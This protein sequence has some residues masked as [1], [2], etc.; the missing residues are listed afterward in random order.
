MGTG[1][2]PGVKRPGRGVNHPSQPSAEVKERVEL[3]L[4][5]PS[6]PSWPVIGWT[7]PF[8]FLPQQHDWL[9]KRFTRTYT[10]VIQ[11]SSLVSKSPTTSPGPTLSTVPLAHT[12][13]SP[14]VIRQGREADHSP[15]VSAEVKN[16]WKYTFTPS[17]RLHGVCMDLPLCNVLVRAFYEH[18]SLELVKNRGEFRPRQTRQPPRAVDLKGR[19][20]S[21]QSY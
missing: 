16:E 18:G 2:F 19:V 14:G 8:L 3:H 9:Y 7:L 12:P 17:T 11:I 5:S 4:Y 10:R 21:C 1:S 13:P 6:G 15:I 20:L